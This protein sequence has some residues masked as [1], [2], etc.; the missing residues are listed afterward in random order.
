MSRRLD[1]NAAAVDVLNSNRQLWLTAGGPEPDTLA[2]PTEMSI[3]HCQKTVAVLESMLHKNGP[4][5]GLDSFVQDGDRLCCMSDTN[6]FVD[7]V[8]PP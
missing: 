1:K 7:V 5:G 6:S 2:N 4:E 8:V 3:A